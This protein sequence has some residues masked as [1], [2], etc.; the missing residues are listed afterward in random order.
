MG[1]LDKVHNTFRDLEESNILQPYMM[2][3]IKEIAKACQAFEVKESAPPIAVMALRSLHSEVAKIYILR[4]CTWMRTTTEEISKDETWVSVSIL[5]R[6]KSPYSIS[7][8]PLAF[9][10]IMTSA[11]DQINLMIQ[12]L[13]SE[14]LKSEDMFMHL[15]EIQESIRLAFL[16]CFL[17]FSGHLE[18]I[19]GE[20]AQTRSNKENFLQNG[21]SHEPTEKTSELLPGSVVDPH[22][23]LLIV[24]SNIGYCKDELCTELYNKYR[25]VWLQSRE[26]DEGDSD[27][28]DLVVCF[29]GLEEKVLA[30]Y[31]FA[32][33]NLIRS[34]AVNYLLDAGIQWGAAPAVKGV[35]DAAVELLHTLVAVHAETAMGLSLKPLLIDQPNTDPNYCFLLRSFLPPS[36]TQIA[37]PNLPTYAL[38]TSTKNIAFSKGTPNLFSTLATIVPEERLLSTEVTTLRERSFSAKLSNQ[39]NTRQQGNIRG[40]ELENGPGNVEATEDDPDME[41]VENVSNPLSPFVYSK[42]KRDKAGSSDTLSP[43]KAMFDTDLDVPIAKGYTQTYDIDYQVF[44]GAKPLLDK[45]LGILVEGLIDTFLSLFH[46]NK[47]KDLRSL[48]ANGFCQLML[49]LEYFETILHPYLT[50]DASES[51]KS[52]QGVLLEKATESVTESVENL[53]HHRR[54]TRGS[55][56]ALADDRQQVMSV[57]PDDLIAL[58]QQFSSELLQAELERTRINT[59]CFV[60]SIPLDMVPEPA[61]AAYA[62]FR[63]SIDSPS[64]SFRGTQAVGSPSFSRQRRR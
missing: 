27:I 26:R 57:S 18:N 4:L 9:R 59:A 12:S 33:A 43:P 42:R 34:A 5:E 37:S 56:D 64:R 20:L 17:H 22:Q 44:A 11:M 53:G 36:W 19:G 23:Q 31:T 2:D 3:A 6:N 13:R 51:L 46:E 25:H 49:E 58:A 47:T 16:N 7:Y 45:T 52:L 21:Y 1:K 28:R 24:L 41:Q 38:A 14:A 39:I 50:Q 48:D 63:G 61:K 8:L 54:S 35:R 55:E 32:K 60:E 30:Q 62:S 40:I 10:S 29:S 15:Q